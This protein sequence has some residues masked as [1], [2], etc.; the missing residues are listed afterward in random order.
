MDNNYDFKELYKQSVLEAFV[1][2]VEMIVFI[3][4]GI[5]MMAGA[6]EVSLYDDDFFKGFL[7][8]MIG[9]LI[10]SINTTTRALFKTNDKRLSDMERKLDSIDNILRQ[11]SND[12]TS[13]NST[14]FNSVD[15]TS[16]NSCKKCG[17]VVS[18][19]ATFCGGCGAS[20][21]SAKS[22][23]KTCGSEINGTAAFC[24]KCGTAIDSEKSIC[25]NCGAEIKGINPFCGNCGF[26]LLGSGKVASAPAVNNSKVGKC[27]GC[28]RDAVVVTECQIKDDYGT[29]YRKLCDNCIRELQNLR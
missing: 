9:T 13:A 26:S 11:N 20:L 8:I 15:F 5:V 17:A 29:R 19:N 14:Q 22:T 28:E 24:G 16:I 6:D 2:I 7:V 23:C 27:E 25:R 21:K 10:P 4:I 18:K 12:F 1:S 3:I